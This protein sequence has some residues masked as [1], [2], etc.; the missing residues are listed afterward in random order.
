VLLGGGICEEEEEGSLLLSRATAAAFVAWLL[1][2]PA[3]TALLASF[4][5]FS[6]PFVGSQS[7]PYP[8][9]VAVSQS[10]LTSS[11]VRL[12]RI[13]ALPLPI[14]WSVTTAITKVT[15][16]TAAKQTNSSKSDT[17]SGGGV[18]VACCS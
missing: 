12:S 3:C 13:V 18:L 9:L 14:F 17:R 5:L 11:Q 15:T 7:M 4:L 16:T 10:C 8:V 1:I 6:V 2:R